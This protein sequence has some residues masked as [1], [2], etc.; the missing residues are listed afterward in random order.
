M[1]MLVIVVF[2]F[3]YVCCCLCGKSVDEARFDFGLK[4]RRKTIGGRTVL[5]NCR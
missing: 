2:I 1:C 3:L 5:Q 4:S